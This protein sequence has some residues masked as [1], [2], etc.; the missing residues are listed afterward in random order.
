L[1]VAF[2]HKLAAVERSLTVREK[3]HPTGSEV[4]RFGRNFRSG[5]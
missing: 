2:D 1:E 4:S 5:F 3:I